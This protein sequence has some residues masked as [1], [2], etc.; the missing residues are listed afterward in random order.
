MKRL[1]VISATIGLSF[2]AAAC[3]STRGSDES[4]VVGSP[5]MSGV[6]GMSMSPGGHAGGG[7][8]GNRSEVDATIEVSQL[9]TLAFDP[10]SLDVKVGET[11]EFVVTND[12]AIDHEFVLGN[13]AFQAAHETEMAGMGGTMP[14]DERGAVSVAPGATK[15]VIWRFTKPGS[16][17]YGCHVAGHYAA[18]MVGDITVVG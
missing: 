15:R 5:G 12:G 16:L 9:D 8:P 1:L 18:G 14:T 11:V 4:S 6:P 17:L 2:V 7:M 10:G 3:G 13:A